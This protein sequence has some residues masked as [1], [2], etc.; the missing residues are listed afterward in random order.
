MA[1]KKINNYK[2]INS[3]K[4]FSKKLKTLTN[5]FDIEE[6]MSEILSFIYNY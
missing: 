1:K 2:L 6:L 5:I 3:L 4:K